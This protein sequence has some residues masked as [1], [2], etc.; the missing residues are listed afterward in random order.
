MVD[1]YLDFEKSRKLSTQDMYDIVSFAIDASYDNGFLNEFIF[2]HALYVFAA[3][4]IYP[5][6]KEE[7][8]SVAAKNI[9][10]AWDKIVS[11]GTLEK[12]G[13]EYTAELD[14]VADIAR[15]W[16][17][18][19][20]AYTLSARGLLNNLQEFSGDIIKNAMNQLKKTSQ[21]EGIS[22]V[23]ELADKWG[24]NNDTSIPAGEEKPESDIFE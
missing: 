22:Q 5:E 1:I 7:L 18:D 11:E 15:I 12:M 6:N 13:D 21:E 3:I 9:N 2:E 8:V 17:D 10:D 16:F 23:L 19:Y 24:M 20:R 14:K 4:I